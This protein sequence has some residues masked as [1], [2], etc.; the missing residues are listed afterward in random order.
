M[1]KSIS[2]FLI[3][4]VFFL[5]TPLFL[6]GKQNNGVRYKEIGLNGVNKEVVK[7]LRKKYLTVH[8]AWL[9]K[10]LDD[11]E[12]YRIYVRNEIEKRKMPKILE[13]LPVVE[14]NYNPNAKSKSGA[15][16]M[17]QFMKNSVHPFLVCNEYV[18]ERLDPW[19]STD[20]AL[21]KLKDNYNTFGDWLLAITA[22]N[23]GVG[24]LKKAISKAGSKDFW[25]LREHKYLSEQASGYVPKLLA[26]ADVAENA[27]YYGITMPTARDAN[28]NTIELRAG[29]FDYV[30][31]KGSVS[32]YWL[33]KE[34]RIDKDE[35]YALNSSLVKGVT[36]PK[37]EYRI[38]LPEGMGEY[39]RYVLQ[40]L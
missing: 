3:V 7:I 33:S 34:L 27:R 9:Y 14:S 22:Y 16:G 17:W 10:T 8:K 39:A 18:D 23:C 19:K 1:K 12:P 38:R 40:R 35:L 11:A 28:G 6:F 24:A 21:R 29:K 36:P 15:T 2:F 13:Y 37:A 26:I 20:G 32:L 30:K 25:Y 4:C 31:V 5:G